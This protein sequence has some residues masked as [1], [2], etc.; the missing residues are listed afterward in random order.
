[1]NYTL[2]LPIRRRGL[3]GCPLRDGLL[4]CCENQIYVVLG[5][6]LAVKLWQQSRVACQQRHLFQPIFL[7]EGECWDEKQA[8]YTARGIRYDRLVLQPS[9]SF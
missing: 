8:L 9:L 7:P 1:M 6:P 5:C 3:G 4:D 2:L